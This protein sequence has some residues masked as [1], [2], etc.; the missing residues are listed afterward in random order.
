MMK[1]DIDKKISEA[2]ERLEKNVDKIR[3]RNKKAR[4]KAISEP[5]GILSDNGDKIAFMPNKM[6][7]HMELRLIRTS[8]KKSMV[9]LQKRLEILDPESDDAVE[10]SNDLVLYNIIIEKIND[11]PEI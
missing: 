8:V 6:F 3:E 4:D 5:K 1:R 10:A 9:N 7:C 11:N 2:E